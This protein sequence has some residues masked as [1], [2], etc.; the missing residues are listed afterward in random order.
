MRVSLIV[1][2]EVGIIETSSPA[3]YPRTGYRGYLTVAVM[4]VYSLAVF[5]LQ[6]TRSGS[7]ALLI[8]SGIY[9]M[10]I[11]LFYGI[12]RMAFEGKTFLLWGGALAA[13]IIG[14]L[15]AGLDNMWHLITTWGLLLAGGALA[16]RLNNS[17][18][19]QRDIYMIGLGG[20]LVIGLFQTYPLWSEMTQLMRDNSA[21]VID[22]MRQ[23]LAAMSYSQELISDNL[24]FFERMMEIMIRLLPASMI[25]G[26]MLQFSIGYIFLLRHIDRQHL[27]ATRLQPFV[28]WKMPFALT[29]IVIVTILIRILSSDTGQII[30]DNLLALLSVYYCLAGVA[31]VEFYLGRLKV[32]TWLK[33]IFFLFLALTHFVGYFV[34]VLMGFVD[35]FADWRKSPAGASA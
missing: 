11:Y 31:V 30:A 18:L 19:R 2:E 14:Y 4:L 15:T 32:A 28:S 9:V 35:S 3:V 13:V 24:A 26:L 29:P 20:V 8:S 16:G 17:P 21:L 5:G 1:K 10:T 22:D 33:L 6:I 25:L 27:Y 7:V 34:T 12:A 23:S